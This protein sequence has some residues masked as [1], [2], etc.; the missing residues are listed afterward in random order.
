MHLY[1]DFTNEA[2]VE[3]DNK[4]LLKKHSR[5]FE[6]VTDV[7]SILAVINI[8]MINYIMSTITLTRR[9][10]SNQK[11]DLSTINSDSSLQFPHSGLKEFVRISWKNFNL[12]LA[13][14]NRQTDLLEECCLSPLVVSNNL[15]VQQC[16]NEEH[17]DDVVYFDAKLISFEF[18]TRPIW[19]K[20]LKDIFRLTK[21]PLIK[22]LISD[23]FGSALSLA[24]S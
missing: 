7:S 22:K 15:F 13:A 17:G 14:G 21:N 1:V 2:D 12:A 16:N 11:A 23:L 9:M 5:P 19:R 3:D 18:L 6:H 8:N 24:S 4:Q 10:P 20:I